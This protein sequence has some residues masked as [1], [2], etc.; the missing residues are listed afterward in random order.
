MK[1]RVPVSRNV[2]RKIRDEV[3]KELDSEG[4]ARTRRHMKLFAVAL[5]EEGYGPMRIC[6]VIDCVSRLCDEEREDEIFWYHVDRLLIE[7]LGIP[8]D[9]EEYDEI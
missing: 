4:E 1:A 3:K 2:R 7:Q 6:R 5:H 8:F 9:R